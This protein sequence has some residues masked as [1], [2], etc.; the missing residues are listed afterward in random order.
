MNIEPVSPINDILNFE[1]LEAGHMDF[2]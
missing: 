1:K 2:A